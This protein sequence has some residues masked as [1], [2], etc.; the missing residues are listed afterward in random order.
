LHHG[1]VYL[2]VLAHGVILVSRLVGIRRGLAAY[3]IRLRMK[4]NPA[5]I[6]SGTQKENAY[7]KRKRPV[8]GRTGRFAQR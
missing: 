7:Q 6:Q 5:A 4:P 3:N 2:R 1:L 8:G